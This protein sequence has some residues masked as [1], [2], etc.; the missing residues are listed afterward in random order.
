MADKNKMSRAEMQEYFDAGSTILDGNQQITSLSEIEETAD[1]RKSRAE[2]LRELADKIEKG[3]VT[4]EGTRTSKEVAA[5]VAEE[6]DTSGKR[7]STRSRGK[8]KSAIKESDKK[9]E[10]D[11]NN[12]SGKPLEEEEEVEEYDG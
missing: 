9:V 6:D 4:S 8:T 10:V 11:N 1:E 5:I 2:E 7:K 12:N 3:E